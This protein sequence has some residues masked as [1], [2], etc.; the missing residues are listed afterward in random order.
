MQESK[1]Y[2]VIKQVLNRY[3]RQSKAAE[4]LG[5]C[6]RQVRR[7][8][9]RVREEGQRGVI[10]R[11]RGR[12]SSRRISKEIRRGVVGQCLERYVGFGPTLVAEKMCEEANIK[13]SRETIR[14][15]MREE[16]I[17]YGRRKRPKHRQYRQR[18]AHFGE[19][20]Q[21]DGS[22]HRWLEER[23]PELVLM[24]C[25]DD[26]T[27]RAF[28]RFF[29]YE[30]TRP[31]FDVFKRYA[32]RY[33]LPC[34]VYLDRHTTY[35]SN[36]KLTVE[37]ELAGVEGQ[38]QFERAMKELGVEV[39]HAN[40][41]Q[42]K[43]R[44]E[45]L[46]NTLQD[47]LVKELRIHGIDTETGA[48]KFLP[49]YWHR[50]NLK[51]SV[52]PFAQGDFHRPVTKAGI[53]DSFLCIKTPRRVRRDFTVVYN[54][55]QYQLL[56]FTPAKWVTIHQLIDGRIRVGYDQK[57]LPYKILPLPAK[58]EPTP[59]LRLP[60]KPV[61]PAPEHPWRRFGWLKGNIPPQQPPRS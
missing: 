42:G 37:E 24:A 3:L 32:K 6:V 16:G 33:G 26:A 14:K 46:F 31:A 19:M 9:K 56:Q 27:S 15:W 45:R 43:G 55:R 4:L 48:N 61:T 11:S 29:T 53:L 47:R 17:E 10:H 51:F 12:A 38:S 50:F 23:G 34:S 36:K 1:K 2:H 41:P 8:V 54:N 49:S 5:V 40:S 7:L 39:I 13:L 52:D 60:Q 35:K 22:H 21:M 59:A 25:I 18:R 44:V 58:K 20:L 57:F 30:G 28:G